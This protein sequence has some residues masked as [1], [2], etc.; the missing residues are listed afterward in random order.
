[1]KIEQNKMRLSGLTALL[2]IYLIS[3]IK[4]PEHIQVTN[5]EHQ[6]SSGSPI[7]ELASSH[8]NL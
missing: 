8:G 6:A 2:R 1:M 4:E 7:K 3:L 5:L